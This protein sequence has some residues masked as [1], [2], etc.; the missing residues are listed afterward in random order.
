MQ[1]DLHYKHGINDK[2][3]LIGREEGDNVSRDVSGVALT[4]EEAAAGMGE[5][6]PVGSLRVGLA[7]RLA[8][9]P[10]VGHNHG[11]PDYGVE[12]KDSGN[13]L[14]VWQKG[15]TG[16]RGFHRRL[17]VVAHADNYQEEAGGDLK[18]KQRSQS[19]PLTPLPHSPRSSRRGRPGT[20]RRGRRPARPAAAEPDLQADP[21]CCVGPV[22]RGVAVLS[23]AGECAVV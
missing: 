13:A 8:Y 15:A 11:H 6:D 14:P 22:L 20:R 9:E 1:K 12:G 5:D 2:P 23:R 10:N 4:Q 16:C 3:S 18:Q 21:P 17:G 19:S 7:P